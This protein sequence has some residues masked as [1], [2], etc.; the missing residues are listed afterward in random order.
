MWSRLPPT[1]GF[2]GSRL[3]PILGAAESDGEGGKLGG[4]T[5]KVTGGNMS[6]SLLFVGLLWTW[7][8]AG[9]DWERREW[10]GDLMNGRDPQTRKEFSWVVTMV[11]SSLQV[12]VCGEGGGDT[13]DRKGDGI[14][15]V[16]LTYCGLPSE[17]LHH[18]G[19]SLGEQV[20][21]A[22]LAL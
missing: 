19:C 12:T 3:P 8:G 16:H 5:S 2:T 10:S 22:E 21:R 4:P 17:P 14:D 20:P 7:E 1:P 11:A 6:D 15:V 13:K 18:G 9:S